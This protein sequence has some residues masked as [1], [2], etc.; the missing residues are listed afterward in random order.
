MNWLDRQ[1]KVAYD[2][3]TRPVSLDQPDTATEPRRGSI[4]GLSVSN[5][6]EGFY[7]V[8]QHLNS[9]TKQFD[10]YLS[11][12][13][14]APLLN[15]LKTKKLVTFNGSFDVRMTRHT[16][17]VDLARSIWSEVQLAR[18]TADENATPFIKL[19]VLGVQLFGESAGDEQKDL[20]ESI[21]ANGGVPGQVW[22]G[23]LDLVGKYAIQDTLLTFNANEH[24]LGDLKK[25][26]LTEFYFREPMPLYQWVTIDM[27]D[28]GV[29]LDVERMKA[30]QA[31]I[32]EDLMLLEGK[33]RELI[34]PHLE[35]FR[36]WYLN[37]NIKVSRSGGFAQE[38][39]K[40]YGITGLLATPNGGFSFSEKSLAL[41]DDCLFKRFIQNKERLPEADI[42]AIQSIMFK[43]KE[44]FNLSSRDHW[45]FLMFETFGEEPLSRTP[46]KQEPQ[47]DDDFLESVKD[48]Y[49]FV[50]YLLD[51]NKLCKLKS[52]YMDRFLEEQLDGRFYARFGQHTTT[53]GRYSGDLQQ[54][55]RIKDENEISPLAMKYTNMIRSFF[56]ADEGKV[57]VDAD[58]SSLE[59]VIFADD[60]G[61]EP[62]L[63]VIRNDLDFYSQ[64][65][66]DALGLTEYSADKNAPNFLKK[67][68]PD[69]RQAA[70]V[71]G[72]GLRYGMESFKLSKTLGIS[73]GEAK[74]IIHHYFSKYPKLKSRMDELKS[75]AKINGFV[76]SKAGRIRHLP[77][78]Q[79]L[80][81]TWGN[82]FDNSLE[83]WQKFNENPEKYKQMK[84]LSKRYWGD[85]RNALNYPIQSMAASIVNAASIAIA[86][87]FS[88]RNI[89]A[90]II[91]NIH[92]EIC[93]SC[94]E[95]DAK[96]VSEIMQRNMEG[97]TKLSVPLRAVPQ[98]GTRYSD[99]K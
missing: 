24:F 80:S 18:H 54:L 78:V 25:Q 98:I 70:K 57:L 87:E 79:N 52:T 66:I 30:A 20:N 97:T 50:P 37:K 32:T 47:F 23:S 90:K 15:K 44:A 34:N 71:Y 2:T 7:V 21:I 19:K 67:H 42:L 3:E 93:C 22:L 89:D 60:A 13:A 64:V 59:V 94:S 26:E 28:I 8:H 9:E 51:F 88:E 73:D 1:T 56:I 5:G 41:L 82:T 35:P 36:K 33:I 75:S 10:N 48:K 43:D 96:T 55:P 85:L 27:E 40:F 83:L 14:I 86:K 63:D 53:T 29:K 11:K 6:F 46:A 12:E 91:M 77:Q 65:A 61:D 49:D 76:K 92:D 69:L 68:R 84:F 95:A 74:N 38:A 81:R 4:I 31:E 39:A 99:V 17:K 58:Y 62:L 45:K 72:L 16:F